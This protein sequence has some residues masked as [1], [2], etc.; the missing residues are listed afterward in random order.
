MCGVGGG[1]AVCSVLQGVSGVDKRDREREREKLQI[2]CC[3][4]YKLHI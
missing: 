4:I 2:N 1:G 3:Q